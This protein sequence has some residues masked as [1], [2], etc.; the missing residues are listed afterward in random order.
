MIRDVKRRQV[1]VEYARTRLRINSLRR[2]NILPPELRELADAEIAALPKDS[3]LGHLTNRCVITSKPRGGVY[4]WR[5]SR[6]VFRHLSDYN[7]LAG[8]QRAMW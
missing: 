5:L 8:I 2:N 7:K 3:T 1:V 6:I 4:P